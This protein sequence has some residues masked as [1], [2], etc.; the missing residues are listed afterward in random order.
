VGCGD[1]YKI[2]TKWV[3]APGRSSVAAGLHFRGSPLQFLGATLQ[4]AP[5]MLA[6]HHGGQQSGAAGKVAQ[7]VGVRW[8]IERY[9]HCREQCS[10]IEMVTDADCFAPNGFRG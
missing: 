8:P 1:N 3:E 7:V 5:V 9:E 6:L 2:A 4:T 10:F